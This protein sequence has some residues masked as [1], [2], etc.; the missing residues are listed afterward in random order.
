MGVE[1]FYVTWHHK[2]VLRIDNANNNYDDDETNADNCKDIV[3]LSQQTQQSVHMIT[4]QE[5]AILKVWARRKITVN[6]QQQWQWE[7]E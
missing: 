7:W 4:R 5:Q 1:Y 2:F 3:Q 6:G